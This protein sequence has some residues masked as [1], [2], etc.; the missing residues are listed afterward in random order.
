MGLPT[1]TKILRAI[2]EG[3]IQRVGSTKIKKVDVRLIAA[4]HKNLESMVQEK[5]FVKTCTIASMLYE[6]KL[7]LFVTAWRICLN[8]L[9]LCSFGWTKNLQPGQGKSPRKPWKYLKSYPWP[10]NVR[11]LENALH[12]ASVDLKGKRIL[13]KDL[14]Q[15]LQA[16]SSQSHIPASMPESASPEFPAHQHPPQ[17]EFLMLVSSTKQVTSRVWQFNPAF[18]QSTADSTQSSVPP[19]P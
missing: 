15:S 16:S 5:S 1:Q 19:L 12:S 8:W 9:T 10:G 11:E 18:S 13:A 4:T 17:K 2:Q 6:S 7:Q 3:E 14:P